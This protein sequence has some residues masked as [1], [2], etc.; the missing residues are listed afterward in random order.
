MSSIL[1]KQVI[2][3]EQ[4]ESFGDIKLTLKDE[5]GEIEDGQPDSDY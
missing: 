4:E 5:E 3:A 1:K 2:S